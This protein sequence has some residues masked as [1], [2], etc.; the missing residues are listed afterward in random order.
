[1]VSSDDTPVPD[2][3]GLL[4]LDGKRFVVVGA[5]QGI[6]RQT[7]HALAS[8]G[9]KLI[10]IDNREDL[11]K[12][13]S[14]EVGGVPCV[15]DATKR[16]DAQKAVDLCVSEFG[17]IDGL[18]DIVGMAKYLDAVETSDDDWAWTFD[19]VLRHAFVFSQAAA[20][21]M[22]ATAERSG[23]ANGGAMVFVASVSGISSAPRHAA[24]GAAKAALMSWVRSLAVELGPKSIRVNAV[25]PGVV[26]TPRVSQYLGEK[27]REGQSRNSPLGRVALPQ[28][29]A[30]AIL[31]LASDLASYVTGQT[32]V[33]DGGVGV[34]FPY[35]MNL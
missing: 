22:T 29:I 14:A 32:L 19:I 26:W 23:A 24:Y 25:A 5:G 21:A 11:A 2:Y 34:K 3:P 30:S 4:R 16:D 35:P 7:A 10:C 12:E 15:A 33:V 31:F 27:G 8:V 13:I 17:G 1:M 20:K 6:G 18:V 9:A 28:D